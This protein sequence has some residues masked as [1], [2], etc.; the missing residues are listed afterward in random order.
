M[1]TTLEALERQRAEVAAQM[2]G[3]LDGAEG[4]SR[5]LSRREGAQLRELERQ[6]E[7]L[8]ERIEIKRALPPRQ[9]ED[10]PGGDEAPVLLAPEQ[11]MQDWGR[12]RVPV[13]R[14]LRAED[15][16][17]FSLG[18]LLRG[19]CTGQWE[20]AEVEQRALSE[21]SGAAG[22]FLTPEILATVIIDKVR[23]AARV[24]QAGATTVP[25]ESDTESFPRLTTDP[26]AAWRAEGAPVVGTDPTFDRVTFSPKSVATKVLVSFELWSDMIDG[27]GQLIEDALIN[28]I[29]LAIDLAALRGTGASN[30]PTGIRNQAGVTIQSLGANGATPTWDNVIDAASNVRNLNLEPDGLIWASR[31]AQTLGKVKDSTGQY[32][33]TPPA[34]EGIQRLISNQIPVN[35]TQGSSVDTSEIYTA[36][37][38]NLLIGFRPQIGISVDRQGG[39]M[40]VAVARNPYLFMD[41]LQLG[42]YAWARADVQLAHPEAFNVTTGVRP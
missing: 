19:M 34:I 30:Q 15:A 38:R 7:A 10:V 24:L 28:A 16:D 40:D 8:D 9:V 35:I 22:G 42:I 13:P 36:A 27:G 26:T 29:A 39:D 4:E 3:L 31:T 25:L 12:G 41:N 11:R 32:L 6:A 1:E 21:G 5:D 18:R 2:S 20:Q 23:N 17:Q 33:A 14:S 37:W